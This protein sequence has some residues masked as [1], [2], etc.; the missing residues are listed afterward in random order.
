[1]LCELVRK[2][3][4]LKLEFTKATEKLINVKLRPELATLRKVLDQIAVKDTNEIFLDP[5]DLEEVPDYMTVVSEPMDISA[6]RKKLDTGRYEDLSDM[7]K[8]FELMINNCL[9]YNDRDTIFYK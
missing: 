2:R 1:M 9:A 5:V 8:D 7:E 4:K 3:E 6:M